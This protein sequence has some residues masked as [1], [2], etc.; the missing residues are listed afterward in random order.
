MNNPYMPRRRLEPVSAAGAAAA[1]PYITAGIMGGASLLG[2]GI[3]TAFNWA[4]SNKQMKFQER[5]SNTAHQ[6]EVADLKAAG[7]NPILSAKYGGASTPPGSAAQAAD[8]SRAAGVGIDALNAA[9]DMA[10]KE[11][12][13]S[14]QHAAAR[15]AHANASDIYA[16]QEGRIGLAINQAY[17]ALM[18]GDL[19]E[20]QR[21]TQIETI[22]NLK[23][24][25]E[26]LKLE[27]QHS[28]YGLDKSKAE[29]EF[30]KSSLG[31]ASKTIGLVEPWIDKVLQY[32]PKPG[33]G[34]RRR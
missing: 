1:S 20:A 24:Q 23:Q 25:R 15:L 26:N 6:R 29:S 8:F 11:A 28:A 18:S 3:E 9:G 22:K 14:N 10:V 13:A 2:S 34:R 30:Y 12:T 17:S 31:A 27:A 4:S 19:S 32:I 5:M 21:Q 7:L 16:T 33:Q